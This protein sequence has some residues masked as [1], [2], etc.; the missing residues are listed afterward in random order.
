MGSLTN[1][2]NHPVIDFA[3]IRSNVFSLGLKVR[4]QSL[5]EIPLISPADIG[6][7]A[8]VG[9]NR[10]IDFFKSFKVYRK[11]LDDINWSC[12]T[13]F[14]P[15]SYYILYYYLLFWWAEYCNLLPDM[16]HSP[17]RSLLAELFFRYIVEVDKIIDEPHNGI[18]MLMNPSLIKKNTEAAVWLGTFFS[19]LNRTVD[20]T[21]IR[22]EICGNFWTYRNECLIACQNA[23]VPSGDGLQQILLCKQI[24]VG[25]LFRTWSINAGKIVLS[26]FEPGTGRKCRC[27]PKLGL[28]CRAN[29]RRYVGP[30]C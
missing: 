28:R 7:V 22:R 11:N 30:T 12:L 29:P 8:L 5:N 6:M 14:Y 1:G 15:R 17:E 20:Q 21:D 25:G 4:N 16:V 13:S 19:Y 24:T 10:S 26:L 27:H 2:G 3:S 18:R 23:Q 9:W